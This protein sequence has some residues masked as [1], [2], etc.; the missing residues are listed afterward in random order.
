MVSF[1]STPSPVGS[2]LSRNPSVTSTRH[3]ASRIREYPT[4]TSVWRAW[5]ALRIRVS[6]S[7]IGSVCDI[8]LLLSLPAGLDHAGKLYAQRILAQAQTAHLEAP[9]IGAGASAQ[10]A[11]V[12]RA[13]LEFRRAHRL[14][15]EALLRHRCY[16]A[17]AAPLPSPLERNGIPRALSSVIPSKSLRAVVPIVMVRPFTLSTLSRLSSGKIECSRR[18]SE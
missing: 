16:A 7:A 12:M 1:F 2:A 6:S 10:R 9:I 17:S 13:H 14:Y 18:P 15:L 11:A 8:N 3:I 4:A 5:A